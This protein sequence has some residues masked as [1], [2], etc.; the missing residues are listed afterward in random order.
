MCE[1]EKSDLVVNC[2]TLVRV[3]GQVLAKLVEAKGVDAHNATLGLTNI[4]DGE[5]HIVSLQTLIDMSN[6]DN[7]PTHH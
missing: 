1:N 7:W 4:V 3:L 5:T 6:P 2:E